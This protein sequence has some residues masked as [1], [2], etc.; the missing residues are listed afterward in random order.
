MR[1]PQ[2]PSDWGFCWSSLLSSSQST[3]KKARAQK[4]DLKQSFRE[5]GSDGN[6]EG[7]ARHF[8]QAEDPSSS[9]DNDEESKSRGGESGRSLAETVICVSK[10]K[11]S[12]RVVD[13]EVKE[14]RRA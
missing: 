14:K 7:K 3:K 2:R 4:S 11:L 1:T 10:N 9:R 5:E 6:E 13:R 12:E 8:L